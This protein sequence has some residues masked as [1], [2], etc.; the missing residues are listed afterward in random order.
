MPPAIWSLL[1]RSGSAH[2][3]L[4]LAVARDPV[5]PA[6]IWRLLVQYCPLR[7][8][9]LALEARQCPRPSGACGG[10]PGVPIATVGLLLMCGRAHCDLELAVEELQGEETEIKT[11]T[12]HEAGSP[13]V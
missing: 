9:E 5:V 6:A 1:L 8:L 3:D 7:Y 12:Q 11:H 4:A 10:G 13:K 2:C